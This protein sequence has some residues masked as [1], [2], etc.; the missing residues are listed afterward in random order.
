MYQQ[1]YRLLPGKKELQQGFS[2]KFSGKHL[3]LI[4]EEAVTQVFYGKFYK[5][6][7]QNSTLFFITG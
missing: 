5:T 2:E 4:E 3:C 6:F 7:H 1:Q